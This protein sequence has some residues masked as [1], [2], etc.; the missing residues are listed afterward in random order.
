MVK[1]W[2][3]LLQDVVRVKSTY[4]FTKSLHKFIKKDPLSHK[5]VKQRTTLHQTARS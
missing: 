4:G 3:Y 5:S 2:N 1:L